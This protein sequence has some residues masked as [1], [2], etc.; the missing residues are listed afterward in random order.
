M[1]IRTL[2]LPPP[3][4]PSELLARLQEAVA[5]RDDFLAIAAHEL[6]SPLHALGLRLAA[7]ERLADAGGDPQRLREE[8]ARTRRSVDRYVRRAVL[9][10]DVTRLNSADLRL[11]LSRV[12]AAELV[13]DV[14]EDHREEAAFRGS[15]ITAEIADDLVGCWDAQML[16]QVLENLVSNA[17]KYGEGSPVTVRVAPEGEDRVLFEVEDRGPGIEEAQRARIFG[18]FERLVSGARERP[19]FGL[20]LWIVGRIVNAHAGTV[21]VHAPA[22]GGTLF[23]V[24]L[25]LAAPAGGQEKKA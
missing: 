20:G 15:S 7:L 13:Q 23:Q 10:L 24:R 18:K 22:G 1:P 12:R 9:L 2:H 16:G 5:A 14:V 6:R 3:S 8:I 19:G 11:S 25:P 21:E 17:I 4:E